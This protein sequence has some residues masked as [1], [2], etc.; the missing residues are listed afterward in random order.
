MDFSPLLEATVEEQ[1]TSVSLDRLLNQILMAFMYGPLP[2][3]PA[4]SP[5]RAPGHRVC[6]WGLS[7]RPQGRGST[8]GSPGATSDPLPVFVK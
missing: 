7:C 2:T 6:V 3:G 1:R 8:N 4:P 5:E